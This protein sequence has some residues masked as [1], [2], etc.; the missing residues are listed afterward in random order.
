MS[1]P[2]AT[3]RRG[4]MLSAIT[5][6]TAEELDDAA[7]RTP[8]PLALVVLIDSV[9][10]DVLFGLNTW[11]SEYE[12]PGGIVEAGEAFVE[13]AR[14]ELE[15]ETAIRVATLDLL[16]YAR[17]ALTDPSREELGAVYR[18][19][20][21]GQQAVASDEMQQFVWRKPLSETELAIS[22]LDDAIAE[23]VSRS[24]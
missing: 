5:T 24:R 4:N 23:W 20:V 19:E 6:A 9:T 2:I 16:G 8:C 22:A 18:A 14:R 12:L 3:D 1:A 17:F 11:R 10:G 21:T 13:A 7:A 15:E